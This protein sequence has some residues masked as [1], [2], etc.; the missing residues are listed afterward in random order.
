MEEQ[1]LNFYETFQVKGFTLTPKIQKN[2]MLVTD[3]ALFNRDFL[4]KQKKVK[5]FLFEKLL[6]VR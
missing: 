4:I 3:Q 1:L 5:N 2:L 6:S